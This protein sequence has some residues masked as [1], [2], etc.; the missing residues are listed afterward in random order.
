M[1]GTSSIVFEVLE[2]PSTNKQ[3]P[4]KAQAEFIVVD[5]KFRVF[6]DNNKAKL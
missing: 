2:Y 5:I 1:R 3:S 6:K 4:R